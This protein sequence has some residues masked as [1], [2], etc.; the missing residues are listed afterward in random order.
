MQVNSLENKKIIW[1]L[2]SA[3]FPKDLKKQNIQEFIDTVSNSLHDNRFKYKNNIMAMNKIL[4]TNTKK[5][6]NSHVQ[7][8]TTAKPPLSN[9]VVENNNTRN[10]DKFT[11]KKAASTTFEKRLREKQTSFNNLLEGSKPKQID[12]SEKADVAISTMDNL[13][14]KTLQDREKEL[15]SITTNYNKSG[16]DDWL[17]NGGKTNVT[18]IKINDGEIKGILKPIDLSSTKRVSFKEEL[19]EEEPMK[20]DAV[21]N[22]FFSRLKHRSDSNLDVESLPAPTESSNNSD[23]ELLQQIIDNQQQLMKNQN[24]ILEYLNKPNA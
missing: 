20:N 21:K 3:S 2:L 9:I 8:I 17:T 1:E 10:Y 5:Y 7:T 15:E 16:V 18:N 14:D 12:F 13:I 4:L 6:L 23:K 24:V 19:S 11:N 22:T